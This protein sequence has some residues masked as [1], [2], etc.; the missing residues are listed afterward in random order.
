MEEKIKKKG[1]REK[2]EGAAFFA[3]R[4]LNLDFVD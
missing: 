3:L 2:K 1:E 4:V